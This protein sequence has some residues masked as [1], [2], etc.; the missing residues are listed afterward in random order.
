MR[1]FPLV[2]TCKFYRVLE[3]IVQPVNFGCG[4][5]RSLAIF[6]ICFNWVFS[7]PAFSQTQLNASPSIDF[8]RI[9]GAEDTD[10]PVPKSSG[11][12]GQKDAAALQVVIDFLKATNGAAWSGMQASGTLTAP[13]GGSESQNSATLTIHGENAFRLDVNA[14][15]G[16]RSIRIRGL[17]G[18]ILESDGKKHSLPPVTARMGL[19]AF[20]LLMDSSFPTNQTAVLDRGSISVNG[21]I[22]HRITVER[23]LFAKKEASQGGQTA[24]VDLYFDPSTHLLVKSV[25]SVQLDSTDRERYVQ[26]V[27]Y[28]DYRKVGTILLPFSYSQTLNG[29]PQWSLQLTQVQ[30]NPSIDISYFQF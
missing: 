13:S 8:T 27:T 21:A 23:P 30:L 19:F 3:R 10:V 12:L 24:V 7:I 25:A 29:Q 17:V 16:Q 15:E 20:P 22:L 6:L 2:S 9:Y 1:S 11:T 28:S 26:A 5:H 4:K 18:Q 14:A